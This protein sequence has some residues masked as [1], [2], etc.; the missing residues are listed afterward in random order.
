MKRIGILTGGGDCPGLNAVIRAVTKRAIIGFGWE[1][2]GI[3]DGFQGLVEERYQTLTLDRVRG[4]L[5]RGG[6]ILGSSNRANPFSYP[7][8]KGGSELSSLS[9]ATDCDFID[10]SDRV[11]ENARRRGLDC[12]IVVGG[13]GT[14]QMAGQLGKKGLAVVGV[15]KTIDNDLSATDYTF[16]FDT[17][18]TTA[19][20]C[21][22]KLHTTAESHDRV[23]V[24]EVMGRYAGWIAL[25]AGLAAGGDVILIPEIPY[26]TERVIEAIR[27]R[28]RKGI[29]YSIVVVAEG[30][31]P[32]GQG[33][34]VLEKGDASRLERLGGA[35]S[36][37]ER[38]IVRGVPLEVRT[39]VLGHVQRGGTP[40]PFDRL[41][42]TR[43]GSAAVDL[44][45]KGQFS[46]MVCLRTPRIESV[47]IDEATGKPKHVDPQGEMV[48]AA[49]A[50]GVE[51]GG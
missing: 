11:V 9:A 48:T 28:Q 5:I 49:R 33:A 15:P 12:I 24:C 21:I 46:R 22:D 31:H 1:V 4:L 37:L 44:A 42:G 29:T 6:T 50:L 16:G 26:D 35:A 41:L 27:A 38:E 30:A 18:C 25:H 34:A 19:T 20:E 51:F 36:W 23:M 32:A 45:A 3:E 47:P 2:I 17:A 7:V 8:P 14:L 10:V 39:T 40:T 43:F 13:D